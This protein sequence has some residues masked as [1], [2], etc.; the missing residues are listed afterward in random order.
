MEI[1]GHVTKSKPGKLT[2]LFSGDGRWLVSCDIDSL[3]LWDLT[4]RT[5]RWEFTEH[6]T[7]IGFRVVFTP[8]GKW[9]IVSS[10][11]QLM[12][13]DLQNPDREQ[14][15]IELRDFRYPSIGFTASADSRWLMAAGFPFDAPRGRA[16]APTVRIFDLWASNPVESAVALSGLKMG[17]AQSVA[18]HRERGRRSS[19]AARGRK[20]SENRR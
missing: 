3:Q 19:V 12:L 7:K 8:D 17:A 6:G 16:P 5:C 18:C 13:F 14:V 15:P 20:S 4:A 11:G 2:G 10:Y 9:L 1:D